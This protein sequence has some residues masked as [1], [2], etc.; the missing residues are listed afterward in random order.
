MVF[1]LHPLLDLFRARIH[2]IRF[3]EKPHR[4]RAVMAPLLIIDLPVKQ[5]PFFLS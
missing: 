1:L 3:Q 4:R 2:A 5:E